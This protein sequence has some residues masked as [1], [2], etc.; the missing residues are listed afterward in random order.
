MKF[1][2]VLIA[3]SLLLIATQAHS[4]NTKHMFSIQQALQSADFKQRLD[5]NIRLY[6]GDQKHPKKTDFLG[7]FSSNKKTN[8]FNKTDKQACQWVL[9][10]ALLSLQDRAK[11]EGG[12]AVINIASYYNKNTVSSEKEYECHAGAVIAGV[13]LIGDVVTLTE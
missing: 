10:S 9:L 8:S 4:R 13:A 2:A 1:L 11:K 6:F 12:N 7:Q 3:T 5:P